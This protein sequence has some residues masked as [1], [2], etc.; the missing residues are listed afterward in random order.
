MHAQ[1]ANGAATFSI[2]IMNRRYGMRRSKA[3]RRSCARFHGFDCAIARRRISHK[4]IEQMLCG[5]S[6]IID[7]AIESCLICLGR[8][9]ETTQLPDKL[10]RRSANFIRRRRWTEVMECLDGS[11]HV[12][13]INNSQLTINCFVF[14]GSR[15]WKRICSLNNQ[16]TR[17]SH[18][19]A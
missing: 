1:P 15:G 4:R 2:M 19:E 10:K 5:V 6:D 7:S 13:I 18:R 9:R 14:C 16:R 8:F 12:G 3:F 11:A 17:E